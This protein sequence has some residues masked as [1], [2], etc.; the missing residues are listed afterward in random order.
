MENARAERNDVLHAAD[1][2]YKGIKKFKMGL[3]A[4]TNI[5]AVDGIAQTTLLS[6][7]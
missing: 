6:Y 7:C 1:L 3:S 4:A 2:E 5:P